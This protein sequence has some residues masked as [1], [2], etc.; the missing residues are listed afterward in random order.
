[1]ILCNNE[2]YKQ[3]TTI[4]T[5][6][7]YKFNFINHQKIDILSKFIINNRAYVC[8]K[9]ERIVTI[10]GFNDLIEGEFYLLKD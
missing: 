10:D 7:I 8:K 6:T 4:D 9:L 5:T 2:I 3:A 1:M